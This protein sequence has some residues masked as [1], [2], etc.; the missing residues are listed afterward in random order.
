MLSLDDL[1]AIEEIK[2]LKGRYFRAADTKDVDGFADVFTEDADLKYDL[3]V[4]ES[5]EPQRLTMQ[6]REGMRQYCI[7]GW[8]G[9][10]IWTAHFG[11]TPEITILSRTEARGVWAMQD[12]VEMRDCHFHGFGHY[13]ETYRKSDGKWRIATLHLTR[14]RVIVT[15]KTAA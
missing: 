5:G 13:R 15:P 14:T 9:D 4:S 7:Q 11:T 1:I 12:I 6:G 2:Q 3:D 10:L 8:S